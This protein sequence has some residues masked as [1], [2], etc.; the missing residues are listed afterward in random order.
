MKLKNI[1]VLGAA[2][3]VVTAVGFQG[4]AG[5]GGR[6]V[7]GALESRGSITIWLSNNAEE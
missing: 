1:A 3:L 2:T 5:A 6:S 4:A 7:T